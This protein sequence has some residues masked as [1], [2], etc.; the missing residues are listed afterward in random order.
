VFSVPVRQWL[1]KWKKR[2]LP[3]ACAA[4]DAGRLLSSHTSIVLEDRWLLS[5]FMVKTTNDGG[6]GSL[7]QAI[8]EGR[9]RRHH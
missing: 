2:P 5:T 8:A 6:A 1:M 4:R 3:E 9:G 7:R